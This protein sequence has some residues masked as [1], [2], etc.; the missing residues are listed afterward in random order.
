MWICTF[1]FAYFGSALSL[2]DLATKC[3]ASSRPSLYSN[4]SCYIA[5]TETK[6]YYTAKASCIDILGYS[7]HFIHVRSNT[8]LPL[9]DNLLVVSCVYLQ[10][11]IRL[12]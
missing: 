10:Q 2:T 5:H 7:G 6:Q 8:T 9:L 12:E 1:L 4:G 3:M 11:K